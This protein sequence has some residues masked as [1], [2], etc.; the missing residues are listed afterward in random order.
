VLTPKDQYRHFYHF[1]VDKKTS[2]PLKM[3]VSDKNNDLN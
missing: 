1:W 2:L 3:I